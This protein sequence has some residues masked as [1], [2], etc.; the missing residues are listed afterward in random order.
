ML[1]WCLLLFLR[2]MTK[3]YFWN[4]TNRKKNMVKTHR[5]QTIRRSGSKRAL[6]ISKS[7]TAYFFSIYVF[8]IKFSVYIRK[9]CHYVSLKILRILRM[10]HIRYSQRNWVNDRW[11]MILFK[12]GN[13]MGWNDASCAFLPAQ[14]W[15]MAKEN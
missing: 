5:I 2:K 1:L 15:G 12:R 10:L 13:G 9:F 7:S 14:L 4:E 6:S 11:K 3:F 8:S